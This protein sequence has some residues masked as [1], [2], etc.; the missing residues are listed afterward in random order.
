MAVILSVYIKVP[1]EE[2]EII[3]TYSTEHI[4][5]SLIDLVSLVAAR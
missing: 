2:L 3:E 5:N 1:F 4:K